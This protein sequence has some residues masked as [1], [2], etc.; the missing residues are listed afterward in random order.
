MNTYPKFTFADATIV[1]DTDHSTAFS[2]LEWR[3]N[4]SG[5][6]VTVTYRSGGTYRYDRVALDDMMPLMVAA[7]EARSLGSALHGVVGHLKG[8]RVE[9]A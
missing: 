8:E 3:G 5:G 9:P 4:I 6:E 1:I 2:R 7:D